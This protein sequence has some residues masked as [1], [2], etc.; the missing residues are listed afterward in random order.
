MSVCVRRN[1][2]AGKTKRKQSS[3]LTKPATPVAQRLRVNGPSTA[4]K[5]AARPATP[6]ATS[7]QQAPAPAKAAARPSSTSS[8]TTAGIREIRLSAAEYAAAL[9]HPHPMHHFDPVRRFVH[10]VGRETARRLNGNAKFIANLKNNKMHSAGNQWHITAANVIRERVLRGNVPRGLKVEA[11]KSIQAGKG[12]SRIDL[13][14][15]ELNKR[16]SHIFD[17]KT[18]A[19]SALQSTDQAKKHAQQL[20]NNASYGAKPTMHEASPWLDFIRKFA[21]DAAKHLPQKPVA[22]TAPTKPAAARAKPAAAK[23]I[24]SKLRAQ[25]SGTKSA[26]PPATPKA[27][28]TRSAA[29]LTKTATTR[30]SA[31]SG[32]NAAGADS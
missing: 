3:S 17:W 2:V 10:E 21:T 32:P 28:V 4:N 29:S 6:A 5:P 27:V 7:Q 9:E 19:K 25:P 15:T 31:A 12:G 1:A 26:K 16:V 30:H 13:L 23:A 11:E 8:S 18:K 24:P 20:K 14:V 22:A